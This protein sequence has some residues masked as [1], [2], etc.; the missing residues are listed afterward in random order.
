MKVLLRVHK[1]W[2]SVEPWSGDEEKNDVATAFLF[3]SIPK[4]LI[5]QIGDEDT[6]KEI[7]EAVKPRNLSAERVKEARLQ[8]LMNEFE[9]PR[10]NDTDSIDAFSGKISE[11]VT[12][13]AVSGQS[14][15]KTKV[16]KKFLNSLPQS[17]YI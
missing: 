17:K 4:N 6:P 3:Q 7:L 10:M 16:M 12:E 2:E 9:H 15:E 5:L 11:L 8:T 1:V 14:L 13:S